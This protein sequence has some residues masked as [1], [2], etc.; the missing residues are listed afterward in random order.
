MSEINEV[1]YYVGRVFFVPTEMCANHAGP[2]ELK[3]LE[4]SQ[5]R[6]KNQPPA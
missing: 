6:A 3:N 5:V 4:G 1:L 2:G